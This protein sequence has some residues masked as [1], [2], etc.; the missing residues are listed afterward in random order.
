MIKWKDT[1]AI[2]AL[3]QENFGLV[4]F[5]PELSDREILEL[6][7]FSVALDYKKKLFWKMKLKYMTKT[8]RQKLI[9]LLLKEK[10]LI[11]KSLMQKMKGIRGYYFAR[12]LNDLEEDFFHTL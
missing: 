8:Q 3:S 1:L 5:E 7:D 9:K 10:S 11:K 12:V 2:K 6:I 4:S